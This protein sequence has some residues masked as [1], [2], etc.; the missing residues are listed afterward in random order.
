MLGTPILVGTV[1]L[2]VL[3][4]AVYLSYIS[5]NGLPF[6]SYYEIKVQ[7]ANADELAKN[8]DVRIGGA[9]V[10][11]ILAVTPEPPTRS[12]PHPYASLRLQLQ[13]NLYP[14]PAGTHY[15]VRLASV[16]GAKY[17]ELIPGTRNGA[18]VP[19]GGTLTLSQ[20]RRSNHELP[21]VDLDTALRTFAPATQR[22][23][24]AA[25][26]SL[27]DALAGRGA[28]LND[29]L[30]STARLLPPLE[31]V[32]RVLADP[33]TQLARFLRGAAGATSTLASV[34]G[35]TTHLLSVGA[36]TFGTL[37]RPALGRSIDQEA[38]T[39]SL[40]TSV[41]NHATP[42]LAQ[43]ARL[44]AA[45]RPAAALLPTAARRLDEIVTAS[46]P[47]FKLV[48][49]LAAAFQTALGAV[50]AVAVDPAS[51]E[52]FRFLG[53][54]D[55]ATFGASAFVGLGAL[56][57]AAASAQLACN[58]TA[59]WLRNFASGLSEGDRT[60]PWLRVMPLFDAQQSFQ[61]AS[62]SPDL[63]LNYYPQE[64]PTQCQAGNEP[65]RGQQRIGSPGQTSTVVDNTAPPAGVLA[66]G[67]KAGLVP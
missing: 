47:V 60:G 21:V 30:Y 44:T 66:R 61:R 9:R 18:S 41:L 35:T 33:A 38:P 23:F 3:V 55:L 8:S 49:Q 22:A 36:V 53:R 26:A 64:T 29:I 34:A 40:A 6:V 10:G 13:P 59:L 67:R 2:L 50:R 27:A 14:L 48:P 65:Y 51:S 62:P 57:R 15:R 32:L 56:L 25:T 7:V 43:L 20:N 1:T 24:R 45:L 4:L 37:R 5:V 19:D 17:L 31:G 42:E 63:H 12:W 39:E 46:T 28:E 11:Q 58:A 52:A 54:N 16:L